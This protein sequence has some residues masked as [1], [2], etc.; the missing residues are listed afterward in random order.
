M[1]KRCKKA[2]DAAIGEC[3]KGEPSANTI[4]EKILKQPLEKVNVK[5]VVYKKSLLEQANITTEEEEEEEDIEDVAADEEIEMSEEE[6]M[7]LANNSYQG[8]ETASLD[9][10]LAGKRSC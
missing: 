2:N 10:A 3:P 4:S 7:S 1:I 5:K 9:E 6:K 8:D